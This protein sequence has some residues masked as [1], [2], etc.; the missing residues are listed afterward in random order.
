MVKDQRGDLRQLNWRGVRGESKTESERDKS[1][2]EKEKRIN[3]GGGRSEK[4][5]TASR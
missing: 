4:R 2:K 5:W 1:E 3:Y